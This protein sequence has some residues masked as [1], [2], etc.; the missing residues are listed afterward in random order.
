M[1]AKS[2]ILELQIE[3]CLDLTVAHELSRWIATFARIVN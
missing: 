1:L 3:M 2:L